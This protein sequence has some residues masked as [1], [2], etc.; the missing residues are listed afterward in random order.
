MKNENKRSDQGQLNHLNWCELIF[1][2]TTSAV[3]QQASCKHTPCLLLYLV[4]LYSREIIC[5]NVAECFTSILQQQLASQSFGNVCACMCVRAYRSDIPS[6]SPVAPCLHKP[7]VFRA[8]ITVESHGIHQLPPGSDTDY[9][10][11]ACSS[12]SAV[13]LCV[14]V[15]VSVHQWVWVLVRQHR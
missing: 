6:D 13:C 10:A 5:E 15:C 1:L 3:N 8:V 4:I 7:V 9:E 2:C 12:P 14:C 11:T